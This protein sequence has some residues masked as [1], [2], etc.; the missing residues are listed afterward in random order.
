MNPG[1]GSP[2]EWGPYEQLFVRYDEDQKALWYHL[3]PRSRPCFNM[4]LLAELK[5]FHRKIEMV[6]HHAGHS[7]ENSSENSF[8]HDVASL[9]IRYTVIASSIPGVFNLGGDL[10]L[11]SKLIRNGDRDGLFRYAE[12]CIDVL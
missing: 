10:H 5:Q 6:N 3:A 7:S 2:R 9:P 11:F 12:A 8:D 4:D 1:S